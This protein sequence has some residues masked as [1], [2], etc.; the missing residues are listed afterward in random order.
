MTQMN[1]RTPEAMISKLREFMRAP[2]HG[3]PPDLSDLGS[4]DV[5][6]VASMLAGLFVGSLEN[7]AGSMGAADVDEAI[8]MVLDGADNARLE[9]LLSAMSDQIDAGDPT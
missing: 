9:V 7:L 6:N 1:I 2:I 5:L 8:E 4:Y 3:E